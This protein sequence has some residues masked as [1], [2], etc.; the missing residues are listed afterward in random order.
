[1]PHVLDAPIRDAGHAEAGGEA[2]YVI[3]GCGLRAPHGHDFLRYARGAGAHPDSEAVSSRGDEVRGLGDGDDVA[4]YDVEGW[5]V[6]FDVF[7]HVD[8]EDGVPLAGIQDDDVEAGVCE[9]FQPLLVF[10]AGADGGGADELF[11]VRQLRGE[12]VVE[13]FHEVGSGE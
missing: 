9:L 5:V 10:G 2:G 6:L 7:D 3:Y 8:L 1:M 13:V 11:A 4:G 12:W